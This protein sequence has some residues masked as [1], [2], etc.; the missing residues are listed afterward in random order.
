M[1]G[2]YPSH[3]HHQRTVAAATAA[4]GTAMRTT[5]TNPF[6]Q[7]HLCLRGINVTVSKKH[8]Q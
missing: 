1:P 2:D 4:A 6:A 8:V 3:T 7:F 5:M